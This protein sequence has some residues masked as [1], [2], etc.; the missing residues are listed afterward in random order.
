MKKITLLRLW[1]C[2]TVGLLSGFAA[3]P[4]L[5]G[6]THR[7]QL[8]LKLRDGSLIL[9]TMKDAELPVVS[10]AVGTIKIPMSRFTSIKFGE[11]GKPDTIVLTNG[12]KLKGET[13]LAKISIETIF[14]RVTVAKE[15]L[16]EIQVKIANG[17]PTAG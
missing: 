17:K 16:V 10:D 9:G 6:D 14:G 12:D 11:A 8:T 4:A 13:R 7:L 15:A 2:L 1:F 3:S 5:E